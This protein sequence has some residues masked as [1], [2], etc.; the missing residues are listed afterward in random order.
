MKTQWYMSKVFYLNILKLFLIS[1]ISLTLFS[2]SKCDGN[3]D[4]AP[5][6]VS[7]TVSDA[8]VPSPKVNAMPNNATG[9]TTAANYVYAVNTRLKYL[10]MERRKSPIN[11][12]G[13]FSISLTKGDPW[14][15]AFID[16]SKI[17]EAMIQGIFYADQLDA[18]AP[19]TS[20]S[21]DSTNVGN[22]V[23]DEF[24]GAELPSENYIT[25]IGDL[26]L[27]MT[28]AATFGSMDDGVL[29]YINPDL[30]GNGVVDMDDPAFPRLKLQ[31]RQ[32]YRYGGAA[33]LNNLR[34]GNPLPLYDVF[35]LGIFG[36]GAQINL[37]VEQQSSGIFSGAPGRFTVEMENSGDYPGD[38]PA[39]WT[40]SA[41]SYG[42]LFEVA[43]EF[44]N[45]LSYYI[46]FSTDVYK[47]PDGKYTFRFY[48]DEAGVNLEKTLTFTNV[49]SMADARD[50][51][52]FVIPFPVFNADPS[53]NITSV[54]Y[55]WMK[56]EAGAFIYATASDVELMVGNQDAAI[57]WMSTG[58]GQLD[59]NG[60]TVEWQPVDNNFSPTGTISRI[61]WA[62]GI[63][64]KRTDIQRMS[65]GYVSNTGI[66]INMTIVGD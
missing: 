56:Y 9:K 50:I 40:P 62:S 39:I 14:I 59:C 49:A 22:V 1:V 61:N 66:W 10:T 26:G 41:S 30:D 12:D 13:S 48:S 55:T 28:E 45:E 42:L 64:H 8:S 16:T 27:N 46:F 53:G 25:Y 4:G 31:W 34:N 3:G 6:G 18:I 65:A 47:V 2:C 36:S 54:S 37:K 19:K 23:V 63:S 33:L 21:N 29:R 58:C 60:G 24:G 32:E 15:L 5:F 38:N 11:T 51:S 43:T 7:G 17:G 44:G 20:T 52:N 35:S 57:G